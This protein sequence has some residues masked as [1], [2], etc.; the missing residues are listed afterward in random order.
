MNKFATDTPAEIEM[1]Q[2]A[3][4][5]AG[6]TRSVVSDHFARGGAGA[7]E[8]AKAV[9]ELCVAQR[10]KDTGGFKFLCECYRQVARRLEERPSYLSD[11]ST[12][13]RVVF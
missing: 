11:P 2:A 10:A 12:L 5:A 6:A 1:L 3:A 8:L 4:A 7:V 9:E 13:L